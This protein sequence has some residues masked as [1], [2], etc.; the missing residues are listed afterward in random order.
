MF[1]AI[2]TSFK[3]RAKIYA[4]VLYNLLKASI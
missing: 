1:S 2:R 3:S 4:L